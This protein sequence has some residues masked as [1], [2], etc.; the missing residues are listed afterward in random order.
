MRLF[1]LSLAC[2]LASLP[3]APAGAGGT[4]VSMSLV[5]MPAECAGLAGFCTNDVP[6]ACSAD[7]DCAVGSVDPRS[8]LSFGGRKG[9][10]KASLRGVVDVL[11]EP[12]TTDGTQGTSDDYI[13]IVHFSDCDYSNVMGCNDAARLQQGIPLKVE[14]R[15]GKAKLR[16]DLSGVLASFGVGRALKVRG[17]DLRLP[18]DPLACPGDNTPAGI[19]LRSY[20][21][22]QTGPHLGFTGILV[23][24]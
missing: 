11:G 24:Q 21:G 10:V 2:F 16:V 7:A 5:P 3:A 23:G 4:G 6:D 12:V 14:L 15:N 9:V 17:A 18:T 20:E 1:L 8:K 22:C 13:L 19:A